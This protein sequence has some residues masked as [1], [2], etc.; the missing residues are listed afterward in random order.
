MCSRGVGPMAQLGKKNLS[1]LKILRKE[2]AEKAK[3]E[4]DKAAWDKE[5]K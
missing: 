2:L 3:Y 1:L 5:R 4:E